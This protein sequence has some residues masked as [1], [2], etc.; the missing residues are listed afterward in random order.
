MSTAPVRPAHSSRKKRITF[1]H[2]D[3]GIGGA[4]R[5]VV[6]AALA[7]QNQGH[8]V[9]I[10]ANHR[11]KSH[12]FDEAR[13]GKLDVRI[14]GDTVFPI[15]IG[16]RFHIMMA[17]ARQLSLIAEVFRERYQARTSGKK[18]D[19]A[20]V[21]R[22]GDSRFDMDRTGVE[23][24]GEDN[25]EGFDDVFFVDQTPATVPA[26][27]IFGPT[28]LDKF[29]AEEE[30]F[31]KAARGDTISSQIPKR[32]GR[33]KLR[34]L[35]Y[36]HYPDQLLARTEDEPTYIRFL[37]TLYRY[38]F[39][40]FEGWAM[41]A[42]DKVVGNSQFSRSVTMRV[43]GNKLGDVG[44]VYPC[45]DTEEK[46]ERTTQKGRDDILIDKE[47]WRGKQVLLSI[48]RFERK[49]NIELAI[50]AFYQLGE[51]DRKGTRLVIAG[52][53]DTRIQENVQYHVEL[54]E[55]A[56]SLGLQTATCKTAL[57]AL[58]VPDEVDV[59]F[60]L[61]VPSLLKETLLKSS[62]LLLY[63]PSHEHF[64]IVPVEA[65]FAG[66]PVLAVNTGGPLETIA[67][68]ETGWLRTDQG[69]GEW[70]NVMRKV[71]WQMSE[72]DLRIMGE[73]GKRRV[74]ERFSLRAMGDN[75]E[76]VINE[77][78]SREPRHFLEYRHAVL[79]FQSMLFLVIGLVLTAFKLWIG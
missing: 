4:E 50:R 53:Y 37:K 72:E 31:E 79:I 57:S 70:T 7:L 35:F 44:I 45:V 15:H 63:T 51:R 52:G 12:C 58:S 20:E 48:N 49:K 25:D 24:S 3:L 43:F 27:K 1:I 23:S 67:E 13:N 65:M 26:L 74:E 59:M 61:S 16:G 73:N 34:I 11:D 22:E 69:T 76:Y 28:I 68:G 55:L 54:D 33:G 38:P 47:F 62:R 41:S 29:T 36:A 39:N 71:L 64:G 42:A 5:L 14:R 78:L 32:R 21:Y 56:Q 19:E 30:Y 66:L 2:P 18:G 6:D 17:I 75:L 8:R 46:T 9:V 60:L 10:Y 77:M 40:F